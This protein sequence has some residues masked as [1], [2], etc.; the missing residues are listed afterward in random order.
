MFSL[1]SVIKQTFYGY[2][3]GV[4]DNSVFLAID[5]ASV[6]NLIPTFYRNVVLLSPTVDMY[7]MTGSYRIRHSEDCAS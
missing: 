6:G 3:S 5:S 2:R 7:W 1:T 4:T